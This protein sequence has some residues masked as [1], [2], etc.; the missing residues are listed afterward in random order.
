MVELIGTC[1]AEGM[2]D[3]SVNRTKMRIFTE[4]LEDGVC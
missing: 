4:G 2:E 1:E 3:L